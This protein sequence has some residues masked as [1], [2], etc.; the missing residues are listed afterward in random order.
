M[1]A[2]GLIVSFKLVLIEKR[3]R[4][5]FYVELIAWARDMVGRGSKRQE[6]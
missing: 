6:Q 1:A 2:Y 5:T 3:G 4:G